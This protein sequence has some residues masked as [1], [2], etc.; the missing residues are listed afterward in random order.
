[1]SE[2]C[3][4]GRAVYVKKS[5]ECQRCYNRRWY[6]EQRATDV[7]YLMSRRVPTAQ[8]VPRK[9]STTPRAGTDPSSYGAAHSRVRARRGPASSWY[10][11]RCGTPARQW[12]YRATQAREIKGTN[13]EGRPRVWSPDPADYDP[14]CLTCHAERDG[15][16]WG[17]GYRHDPTRAKK[18]EWDRAYRERKRRALDEQ[19]RRQNGGSE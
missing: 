11:I 13:R 19:R 2:Q 15:R 9:P 6:N 7:G 5:G 17:T 16:V 8:R 1:M 14:M 12:A 10:C 4:C 18:R 3:A